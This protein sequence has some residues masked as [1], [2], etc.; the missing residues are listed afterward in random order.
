MDSKDIYEVQ[1]TDLVIDGIRGKGEC[2]KDKNS[3]LYKWM[4]D[5]GKQHT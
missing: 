1:L 2:G 4:E 5:K 3:G